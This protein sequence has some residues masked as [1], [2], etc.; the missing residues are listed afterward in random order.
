MVLTGMRAP[1]ADDQLLQ[2]RKLRISQDLLQHGLCLLPVLI[3]SWIMQGNYSNL[4]KAMPQL[5]E[6]TIKGST[7]LHLGVI[8]HDNLES[9]TIICGGMGKDVIEAWRSAA[10]IYS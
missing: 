3:V 1:S 10:Y 9:L 6:L 5:K 8:E 4:W 2:P 7:D